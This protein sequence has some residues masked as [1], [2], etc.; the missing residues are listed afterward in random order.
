[1]EDVQEVLLHL[2]YQLKMF[3]ASFLVS[4]NTA[5]LMQKYLFREQFISDYLQ[6]ISYMQFFFIVDA[7]S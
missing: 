1:M 4:F 5:T 6:L 7:D 2:L 3:H